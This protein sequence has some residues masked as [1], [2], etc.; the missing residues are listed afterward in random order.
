MKPQQQVASSRGSQQIQRDAQNATVSL[1]RAFQE[2]LVTFAPNIKQAL[3]AH[4]S[5]DKFNRVLVTAVSMNPDL[6]YANR[7]TLFLAAVKCA[8]DGLLA[9]GR[10]AA[11]VVFSTEV[12]QRDPQSGLDQ[13]FRINAVQYM[14]MIAGLRERMRRTGE[15]ASADAQVVHEKDVFRYSLGDDPFIKH[16][17]PPLGQPRGEIVGAYAIIKLING[18][19]LRDIMSRE[20]IEKTRAISRAKDSPMW[21]KFYGE[22]CRK[23]VLRRCSK[24]APQ[25]AEIER[26]LA[27][28][29]ETPLSTLS[30]ADLGDPVPEPEPEHATGGTVIDNEPAEAAYQVVASDGEVFDYQE[31]ATALKAL[32]QIYREAGDIGAAQL[33]GVVESNRLLVEELTRSQPQLAGDLRDLAGD[34][35]TARRKFQPPPPAQPKTAPPPPRTQPAAAAEPPGDQPSASKAIEVPLKNGRPDYRG[36][37]FVLLAPRVRQATSNAEL[38]TLLGDNEENLERAKGSL[39]P[40][41]RAE[42]ENLITQ[43]WAEVGD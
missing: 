15:V 9:D 24:A 26:L 38:A 40:A 13:K 28:E 11:L 10:Q 8:S 23:T 7:R 32:A 42:L 17:P 34:L 16:E 39:V 29:E 20:D 27:R 36:W 31:P 6:L 43:Q 35:A 37:C 33:E 3:P 25:T 30:V 2:E 4:V 22:A 14:P 21:T 5:L 18:E 41:D 1:A 12:K 19:V